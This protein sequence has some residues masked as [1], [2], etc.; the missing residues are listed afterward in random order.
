MTTASEVM[1]SIETL[2]ETDLRDRSFELDGDGA[3]PGPAYTHQIEGLRR[4]ELG[5]GLNP[6]ASGILHYPTGAGKTRVGMELIARALIDNPKHR[7][8]W[9]THTKNLLRQSMVRLAELARLFPKGLRFEWAS[10]EEV[11]EGDEDIHVYFMT[12]SAL[13]GA[14]DRAGDGRVNHRWRRQLSNGDPITLIYD[15]CHQLGADKLQR[16]MHK[17]YESVVKPSG[18]WSRPWR[19]I[20][21]SATPVPTQ[22][23]THALLTAHVFPL[24]KEMK[25]A[26]HGWPFHV[27]QKVSNE[28]LIQQGVLCPINPF[29]TSKGNSI[30][31]RSCSGRS[32]ETPTSRRQALT[33]KRP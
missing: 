12:R 30:F 4:V 2:E 25:S 14:L 26:S 16:S 9:A 11:E 21:L 24:R 31:P 28:T 5:A 17:F 32:S 19:T 23:S 8:V 3:D 18:T 13:T 7:F 15:E 1:R 22:H 33:R 10:A 20:G 27:F 6:P 29:F